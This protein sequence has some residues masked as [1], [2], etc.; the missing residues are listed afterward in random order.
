MDKLKMH[1]PNLTAENVEKLKTRNRLDKKSF[2][3]FQTPEDLA[4]RV[5]RKLTGARRHRSLFEPSCGKGHFITAG[6]A[7]LPGIEQALGL[8]INFEYAAEATARLATDS[9]AEIR[10]GNFFETDLATLLAELPD[11]LLVIGNP[12]WVT[13]ADQGRRGSLNLPAKSNFQGKRGLDAKT[14]RANFDVSEW[15]LIRLAETLIERK[16]TVA[17]LVKTSVARRFLADVWRRGLPVRDARLH[18]IDA[19]AEFSV[20]VAACLLVFEIDASSR[21]PIEH[22]ATLHDSLDAPAS[23]KA[24]GLRRQLL[25]S[26]VET[27]DRLE[28]FATESGARWRSGIKHDC[29]RLLEL[30]KEG[31]GFINGVGE[32]VKI[33]DSCLYP[34]LKS[35]DLA[36]RDNPSPRRYLLVPQRKPNEDPKQLMTSAPRTWAYLE[37]HGETFGKRASSIYK[38]RPSYAIFGVGDYSFTPWKVAISGLHKTLA[39]RLIGPSEGRPVVFDDT[40]YFLGFDDPALA[41]S[42]LDFLETE[43][44][45]AFLESLIFWDAKRPITAE[46]LGRI[47]LPH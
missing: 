36:R 22:R 28:S 19:A 6:L 7:A 34:L 5:C 24:F 44:A 20:S 45:R 12:P 10:V 43:N 18:H 42:T 13:N 14:G 47:R 23:A 25:V 17:M 9:R 3:D 40:C 46:V 21:K 32:V 35:T 38:N 41:R 29:A 33:E 30:T 39:F 37:K 16:A 4:R 8:E 27:Y 26:D 1:T 11:P 31:D 2:G 15:M